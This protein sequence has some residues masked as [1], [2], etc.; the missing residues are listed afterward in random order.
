MNDLYYLEMVKEQLTKGLLF[1]AYV[2]VGFLIK[3]TKDRKLRFHLLA[4]S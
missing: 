2:N 3:D 1:T 4:I